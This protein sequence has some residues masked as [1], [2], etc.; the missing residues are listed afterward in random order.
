MDPAERKPV[1]KRSAA[2]PTG[3]VFGRDRADDVEEPPDS[4]VTP[5]PSASH[6]CSQA[7]LPRPTGGIPWS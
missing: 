7:G 4:Q 2:F 6:M 3:H 5:F 1:A